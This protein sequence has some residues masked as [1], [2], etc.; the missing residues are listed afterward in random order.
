MAL[1]NTLFDYK[2]QK[3]DKNLNRFTIKS[4]FD[5]VI[6]KVFVIGNKASS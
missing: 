3:A 6:D 5:K 2:K 4:Y 1:Q